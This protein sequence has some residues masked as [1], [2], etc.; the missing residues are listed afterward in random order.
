MMTLVPDARGAAFRISEGGDKR[1][2]HR[3]GVCC[4]SYDFSVWESRTDPA[5]QELSDN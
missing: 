4:G 5:R 1:P 3:I 2:Q